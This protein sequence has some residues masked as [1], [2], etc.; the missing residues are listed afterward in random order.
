MKQFC[1]IVLLS[2][3]IFSASSLYAESNSSCLEVENALVLPTATVT[4][5]ATVC[6]NATSPVITFKG[7]GGT[8]PYVFTYKINGGADIISAPSTGDVFTVNVPTAIAGTFA[9][10]LVS[11]HDSS[12]PTT[13]ILQTGTATVTV[14]ALP[15]AAFSFTN[16]NQ[17]SGTVVQFTSTV[18]TGKAPFSYVWDF[19]DGTPIS[20]LANPSHVFTSLGCA[21]STYTVTLK[22]TDANGCVASIVSHPIIVIQKPDISFVDLLHP[23]SQFDNCKNAASNSI[24]A[25]NVGNNSSSACIDSSSY[26]IDWGDGSPVVSNATFPASHTYSLAGTY[27][28]VITAMGTN[29]CISSKTYVVKNISN[30]SGGIVSPGNTADLCAPTDLI[31]FAISGWGTNSAGTVYDIDYG[32]GT[33]IVHLTQANLESSSYFNA[34]NP[35]LSTNFPIPHSYAISNC[36]NAEFTVVLNVLNACG[37]TKSSVSN[38]TVYTKPVADFTIASTPAC[39]NTNVSFTNT[40]LAGYNQNCV[41]NSLY[42]WDFGDGTTSTQ[43]SP[44]HTYTVP[45]NYTVTLIAQAYC[46]FS[47]PVQKTICV[48]GPLVPQFT[49]D[50]TEGCTP[51]VVAT[52]NTTVITNSCVAPTYLWTVTYAS[53]NCGVSPAVWNYVTGSATSANPTFNFLTPGTYSIRLST[54]NSCGTVVSPIQTVIVKQPPTATINA[55][56]DFCGPTSISPIAIVNG[57][58]PASST[59]TYAWSFPGGTPSSSTVANPG[60][61]SYSSPGN[62]TVSLTVTNECGVSTTATESFAIKDVPVITNTP[63]NQ[64]ICSGSQT[65]LVNL[66]SNPIGATYSWTATATSGITG[67]IPSGANTIPIQTI[68]TTSLTSGTVTYAIT[69]SLGGCPGAVVN[70]VIT[71]IPAPKITNQPVSNTACQNGI[72]APLTVV[73]S[74][75]TGTPTYQWYSNT[76]NNNTSGILISGET[77]AT[78]TPSSATVGTVYYY[79]I[80]T[81][82]SGGCSNITST[83]A[84]ITISPII[85]IGTQPT[86]SQNLCVGATIPSP[87]TVSSSGGTGTVSYQWYSNTTNSNVGGTLISGATNATYTPPVFSS[88]G[89]F[90]FY[91]IVS[92][93][94]TGCGSASSNVATIIVDTDPTVSSQ[95]LVSQT[96]CQGATPQSLQVSA[97]GGNGIFSYQWFSNTINSNSGGTLISGATTDTYLPPT[98]IVGTLYYYCLINQSTLGCSVTSATAAVIVNAAPTIINQPVSSTVCLG[99]TPTVLSVTYA[100]GVGIPSY[101]WYSNSV[102]S[103]SGGTL[104]LGATSSTF[105]PPNTP[106]GTTFYY[107]I[108]TLPA[109]GGCSSITSN[110][111]NVTI[112]AGA[113]ITT[114]PTPTQS[115]C[116]GGTIS[117]PLTVSSSGGTGAVSYQWYS[118]TTNSNSGGILISGATNAT[119]TPAVF[120]ISGT[121]YYYAVL[122]FSGSGCGAITSNVAEIIVVNDPIITTQ[123]LATQTVCQNSPSTTLSVVASGGIATAYTYQWFS[124]NVNNTSSGI[125]IVGETNATFIPPTNSAGT[126]YYYCLI[127]QINGASCAVTTTTSEVIINLA[128]A[129]N[130]QPISS[131]VCVNGTPTLLSFTYTNGV[132]TPTYQWFSNNVNSN[133]GG[134][135]ISGATNPTFAPPAISTGTL[136]YYCVV[137]FASLSGGCSVITTLP[138]S[139]VVNPN[140]VIASETATICSTTAFTVSPTNSGGNIVPVGTTYTWTNPTVSPVGSVTGA[141]AEGI[142]QTNI[143]QNLINTTTNP[144]TVTYTVTPKSGTCVG[145]NFSV[146]VTVNPSINP[147]SILKNSTCFGANNGSIQTTIT[148]GVPFSS[149]NPYNISWTGPNGFTASTSNIT[150]LSPGNYTISVLDNG[151]CPFSKTYTITEPADIVITTDL[152]KDITCFGNANGEIQITVT[153]GTPVYTYSW[154]K[155]GIPFSVLEDLSGLSPGIYE[156]TVSDANNCGPKKATFTIT[157]SPVLALNLVSKT[158]ILCFGT[159]TGAINVN[160]VGGTP[161]VSG[162]NFAWTGP[163]GFTSTNQNLTAIPAGTY[164]L[165]VTDDSGCSKNLSVTLTQNSEITINAVTTPIICYGDNDGS[166]TITISGGIAPYTVLWSNLGSGLYQNNLSAGDYLITVTDALGCQKSLNVNIPEPPI[167][168]INPVVKNITC[169]GANNGSINLN[170]VGGIAPVVLKWNDSATAGNVRNNLGPGSYTVTITDSKPCQIVRTFVIQEPQLLVLSANLTHALDCNDA[171]T[172][173]INLLVSG[174]SAPF[175]YAWS[176]GATTEDLTNIP[177]GNY[178][179]TVTDSRGCVKTAQYIINRPPPIVVAVETKTD[180]NCDTKYVKQTFIAQVSGG[181]PPYQ[182]HWSSGTVSG[183]NNEMMTTNQN[184]T[185]ILDVTDNIGCKANYTFNVNIPKL[186]SPSFFTTS[187]AFTTYGSYSIEDPIQFTNAA[188]GDYTNISWDFGDG[189]FSTEINPIHIYKK[190]GSYIVNQTVTYPFGCVYIHTITLDIKKG[191]N[192]IPPTAFTPNNDGMNDY[193]APVF[194][195]LKD[196]HF[197][198]YDTW[199]AL[200]YSE[201]GDS[202]RGWDG[203]INFKEAE[204]GNYYYKIIA[205]A[206]YGTTIK[207]QGAFVLIK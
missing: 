158:D 131:S 108:I 56:P 188:T 14:N 198:V 92:S 130:N 164:N 151:G 46:G 90:Y 103:N 98:T 21:T 117:N 57:C 132:G 99:G 114:Q 107:C 155:N 37:K 38:I 77:N 30:P 87:L 59:M 181:V 10:T 24:F 182:L 50:K 141:S 102:N 2:L 19:G 15:V 96:L 129:I 81:L 156:V 80:I 85:S 161:S 18:T 191:Y 197:D 12:A 54:T 165:T 26:T 6:Q 138:A 82:P 58:A 60:S 45:G 100:N 206:F 136:Y 47:A 178:L 43:I 142:P 65:A 101:Q 28:M 152:E 22:V 20:T 189:T 118:N 23:L 123:P 76:V 95:P 88:Q 93:T 73:L 146:V 7:V 153:S 41:Q 67:F 27:N 97:T 170:I 33:P 192:L 207:D 160:V 173:A 29:S 89:T 159:A 39:L 69:P 32:D 48:E 51:L 135:I 17:C 149:G 4:G 145:N 64:T 5:N 205:K 71:V 83:T 44:N 111:A 184:G 70:Y 140:P 177:A 143:T 122:N 194:S 134:T 148:G 186:G 119:F 196:I 53:G 115:L 154:T 203:K 163:N 86:P 199:G 34:V 110:T 133:S 139:V 190:E 204:N 109:T 193:F 84:A 116:V 144:S 202:I 11:V 120:T 125:S 121:Y 62:Y 168:T 1:T 49:L 124:A 13:E 126:T 3:F 66:T 175:T 63:L 112:N 35:S 40:S 91:A 187:F 61:I 55:I 201:S 16:D 166:I 113:T 68:S 105:S 183:V 157:E 179:V 176:N 72:L 137:T 31:N 147:N 104:I 36:P 200:I 94:G 78:F 9:Y 75:V 8:A 79:C 128:P 169:F 174:G 74:G 25:I 162:Y 180:F 185:V 106:V 171:N 195:G 150:N 52:N 127:S 42:Q 172:G 167:F